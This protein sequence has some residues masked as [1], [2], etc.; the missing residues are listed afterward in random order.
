MAM[1]GLE[2]LFGQKFASRY[3]MDLPDPPRTLTVPGLKGLFGGSAGEVWRTG[4]PR[5]PRYAG[6]LNLK[7]EHQLCLV[8]CPSNVA[9]TF[10]GCV[11]CVPREALQARTSGVLRGVLA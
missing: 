10:S 2:S 7:G 6:L 4:A 11:S 5:H 8:C 3:L 9:H 1:N